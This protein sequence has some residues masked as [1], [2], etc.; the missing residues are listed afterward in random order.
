MNEKLFPSTLTRL[1]ATS[2]ETSAAWEPIHFQI[3][4]TE[5]LR[6]LEALLAEHPSIK[7]YDTIEFQ[8]LELFETR[9]PERDQNVHDQQQEIRAHIGS[10]PIW[11]YGCW[12]YFPWSQ[13]LVHVLPQNEYREL[14]SNRNRNKITRN[15]QHLLRQ[16]SIGVVG[17]SVGQATAITMAMEEIGG[18]FRLADFDNLGLSNLNRLRSGVHNLGINKAVLAAREIFEI[19]PYARVSVF[20]EGI[21][22]ENIDLF[23]GADA[24]ISL[25]FEECDDLYIKVRLR[26]RA[27]ALRIPVLMETSDRG[28][29]DVERFDLEPNR[30][31]MHGLLGQW[32]AAKLQGLDTYDKVPLVLQIL[33]R[34]N[35]STRLAASM[36]EIKSTLKSWPQLASS[37]SLGGAVNTDVARR[38]AL[39][40]LTD[41]GRFYVDIESIVSNG[42]QAPIAIYTETVTEPVHLSEPSL[43]T[44]AN[45]D[46]DLET[47]RALL[48]YATM[49]PSGGNCQPWR[50]RF[51]R[52]YLYCIHDVGRSES[53]LDYGHS[54]TYVAFGALLENLELAAE[55]V[56]LEAQSEIFPGD[57]L[58]LVARVRFEGLKRTPR[59]TALFN[60]IA[61]RS[62]NRK[63]G[64]RVPLDAQTAAALR[65]ATLPLGA[66]LQ[67]LESVEDLN[68]LG[69]ILGQGDRLRLLHQTLHREMMS[70]LRWNPAEAEH[71]RDGIDIATLEMTAT[72]VAALRVSARWPVMELV[73]RVG[74]G[75]A[76]EKSSRKAMDASSAAVLITIAGKSREDRVRGGRALQRL[77]LAATAQGYAVQPMTAIVYLFER[78]LD[79]DHKSFSA[80][81]QL[82]LM[83]L[84]KR[85][86]DLF[87]IEPDDCEIMLLRL[88]KAGVPSA[89]ALRRQIDDILVVEDP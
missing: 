58:T 43:R 54:G 80:S 30:P 64:A 61:Q 1:R 12:V 84:R 11:A 37:V 40:Q 7:I 77:W 86:L 44:P 79:G 36:V 10:T 42:A 2:Y 68:H 32:D 23:L 29:I 3:A 88:A 89:R 78:I 13:R 41:S 45:E 51:D 14:R 19:N 57:D 67:F 73:Q 75:Q 65:N 47:L 35:I 24:P 82:A 15:E 33:G 63:L 55:Q 62:T 71:T 81:E 69:R 16:L 87:H 21:T 38:I 48:Q 66:K 8:L 85:Y 52:R 9:H 4:K 70:E 17:L 20:P 5:H 59:D 56:G 31:L 46:I 53:F 28:L 72:D 49:A 50:F 6:S 74:G 83:D 27:R 25:L 22:E 34:E 39:G 26:E 76:L 60:Q 18:E